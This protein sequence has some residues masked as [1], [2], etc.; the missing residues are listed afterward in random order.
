[1]TGSRPTS[2][3]F[4]SATRRGVLGVLGGGFAVLGGGLPSQAKADSPARFDWG[5][6]SGDPRSDSVVLWTRA[7]PED[8]VRSLTVGFELAEDEGF[9]RIVRQGAAETSAARDFTVKLD[10]RGLAAGRTPFRGGSRERRRQQ[11]PVPLVVFSLLPLLMAHRRQS[12]GHALRARLREHL[13][14]G[15]LLPRPNV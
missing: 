11:Q 8:D 12:I 7:V 3:A 14:E 6:A 13:R 9:S 10:V 5:V 1:M 4:L 15:E 2:P